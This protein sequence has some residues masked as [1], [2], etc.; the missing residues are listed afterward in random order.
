MPTKQNKRR[1]SCACKSAPLQHTCW[2]CDSDDVAGCEPGVCP[3]PK[4]LLCRDCTAAIAGAVSTAI[5]GLVLGRM[6]N[7]CPTARG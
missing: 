1:H 6:E 4:N 5:M 3:N 2:I 7:Q